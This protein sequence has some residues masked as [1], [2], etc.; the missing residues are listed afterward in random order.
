MRLSFD[1][2][3]EPARGAAV[4]VAPHV[5][6]LTANNASAYTF[7]GTNT[8]LVGHRGLAVIDPGPEGDEAHY[9]ALLA[10]IAG[11]PVTHVLVSHTHRDH[12]P[13]ARRLAGETGATV[14]AEGPHR[15]ARPLGPDE[16]NPFEASADGD[17]SPD[18]ALRDGDIVEGDGWRIGAVLT[19]GHTAN[20]ACFALEGTGVLFSADHVM[21]WASTIIAPPDGA[22]R[23]YMRSL[24]KL[25][26]REDRLLLPGHGGPVEK[27][28]PFLRALKAHRRMRERAIL[29]RVREGDR[30]VSTIVS[31]LYRDIDPRLHGGAGLSVL[32]HLE[33]LAARGLVLASDDPPALRSA[34]EAA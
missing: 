10:S 17:F 34:F 2:N 24:D 22:M 23:D 21:A 14:L 19:P 31:A 7:A 6:R 12:S 5:R 8:Y 32:A 27:P 11:R 30:S 1:R 15:T 20:H 16:T 9:A 25:I 3:F 28:R 29:Q 33:D 4:T 26:A 18:L 13:L